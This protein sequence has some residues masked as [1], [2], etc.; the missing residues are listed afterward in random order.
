MRSL[1]A[2]DIKDLSIFKHYRIIRKWACKNNNLNDAD[3][4]L[5]IY[6]DCI[7]FFSIK[8]FKQ[9]TYSYSWD[10]RRW[11][12]LIDNNWVVI[13]RKRNRSTQ[14]NNLYQVSFKGKQLIK[15]IYRIILGE[16][17]LPISKRRNKLIAG[18][19]YTDKVLTKAI[20]NVNKDKNR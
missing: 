8:D 20:Y 6:L 14:K 16:E 3:L 15:R 7:G 10:T 13:W 11:A 19:S 18:K 9:G 2:S 12:K 1:T 17:D 5:L 4:E